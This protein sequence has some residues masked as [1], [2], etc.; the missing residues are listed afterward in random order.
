MLTRV[1]YFYIDPL[2]PLIDP[3]LH[4]A[5]TEF[6]PR[7]FFFDKDLWDMAAKLKTQ[8]ETTGL[9]QRQ[10]AEALSIVLAHDLL[11]LNR[12]DVTS[13]V[14]PGRIHVLEVTSGR[15]RP[16]P[17]R[18]ISR[19]R[20]CGARPSRLRSSNVTAGGRAQSRKR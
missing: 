20:S 16:A 17:G 7:L 5:E 10:Y 6:K 14:K 19:Y 9:G 3:E 4:F 2:G 8:S 12:R 1:T 11:R 18:S 13:A 15:S